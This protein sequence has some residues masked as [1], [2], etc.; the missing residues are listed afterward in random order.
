M[1]LAINTI[2]SNYRSNP[3]YQ[4][5]HQQLLR[6]PIRKIASAS[7]REVSREHAASVGTDHIQKIVL[8]N[9]RKLLARLAVQYPTVAFFATAAKFG[10]EQ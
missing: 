6:R 1:L 9:N 8:S 3:S 2:V 7:V 4:I 5:C 10:G